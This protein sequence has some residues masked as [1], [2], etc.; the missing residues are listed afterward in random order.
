V[1]TILSRRSFIG[2]L[3]ALVAAPAI[4]RVTSLMPVKAF[5]TERYVWVPRD[6]LDSIMPL[7]LRGFQR[8]G[9]MFMLA[10]GDA[11]RLLIKPLDAAE[12]YRSG[13]SEWRFPQM[14]KLSRSGKYVEPPTSWE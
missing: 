10:Q 11:D 4:V 3:A 12:V 13:S 9:N 1:N 7:D 6:A 2:G 8:F 5:V 14:I